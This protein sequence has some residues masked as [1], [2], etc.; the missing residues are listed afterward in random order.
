MSSVA[1]ELPYL[2]A[3]LPTR[4]YALY[5]AMALTSELPPCASPWRLQC[6]CASSWRLQCRLPSPSLNCCLFAAFFG[7]GCWSRRCLCGAMALLSHLRVHVCG[8]G[9]NLE[10]TFPVR[11]RL[12]VADAVVVIPRCSGPPAAAFLL[13]LSFRRVAVG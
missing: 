6:S 10:A 11:L 2:L 9:P 8:A 3:A 13:P 7:P 4:Q 1:F 5:G 12:C